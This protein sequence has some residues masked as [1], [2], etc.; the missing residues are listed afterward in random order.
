MRNGKH[1]STCHYHHPDAPGVLFQIRYTAHQGQPATYRAW[2][3]W[4]PAEPPEAELEAVE[5]VENESES[6]DYGWREWFFRQ[7]RDRAFYAAV[8]AACL[9]HAGEEVT[10]AQER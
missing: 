4:S 9:E 2:H 8:E 1:S 7:L 6:S 10:E 5:V 3:G